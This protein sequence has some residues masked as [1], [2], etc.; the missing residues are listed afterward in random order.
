MKPP[1]DTTVITIAVCPR[2]GTIT[3]SVKKSCCGRG[4]SW[5]KNCGSTGKLKHT[6]YEGIQACKA[7]SQS[8]TVIIDQQLNFAQQKDI[9]SSQ[10]SG[11]TNYKSVIAA[12][13]KFAFTSVNIST[14]MS[15][16]TLI[17]TST[18][19]SDN[20]SITTSARTLMTNTST[21]IEMTYSTHTSVSTS[22]TSQGY[23]KLLK[24]AV[25]INILCIIIF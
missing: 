23:S 5:F 1:A 19:A 12:N 13:K 6:W 2:C 16:T 21:N 25:H 14:L 20:M 18:Y 22:T 9:E 3:K 7:R 11:M 10:G 24:I 17:V 15:D 4:G 8:K